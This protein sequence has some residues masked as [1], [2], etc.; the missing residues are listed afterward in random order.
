MKSESL[1]LNWKIPSPWASCT[2]STVWCYSSNSKTSSLSH[3]RWIVMLQGL[4]QSESLTLQWNHSNW[5]RK[6]IPG[7]KHQIINHYQISNSILNSLISDRTGGYFNILVGFIHYKSLELALSS[8][9]EQLVVVTIPSKW[10][11]GSW[12]IAFKTPDEI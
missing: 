4:T 9:L 7:S 12:S 6:Q 5:T 8:Q 1:T 2:K 10:T 3:R 11:V